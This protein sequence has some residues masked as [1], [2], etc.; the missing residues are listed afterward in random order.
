MMKKPVSAA[1]GARP[2]LQKRSEK[3]RDAILTALKQC[4]HEKGLEGV[5][6]ADIAKR[7]GCSVGA[8]YGRFR[9]KDAALEA[10]YAAEREVL[11]QALRVESARAVDLDDWARR[12]VGLALDHASCN[13]PLLVHAASLDQPSS[14]IFAA[15]RIANLE[16]TNLLTDVFSKKFAPGLDPARAASTAAFALAMV[17]GMTRD[18]VVYS[19]TLLGAEKTRRWFIDQLAAAVSAYVRNVMAEAEL[20]A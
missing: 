2:V 12:V 18:A 15:A 20:G 16:I 5:A 11:T 13:R 7:A 4:L 6:V 14:T 8:F 19:K 1:P 10:L 17:G 3:T 9:D